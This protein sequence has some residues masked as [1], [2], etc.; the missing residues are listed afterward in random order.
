MNLLV[1]LGGDADGIWDGN[2]S[3]NEGSLPEARVK[4]E[5]GART[6]CYMQL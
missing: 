5:A 3:T 6:R 1:L 2:L 4:S